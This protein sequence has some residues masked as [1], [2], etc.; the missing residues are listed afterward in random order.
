MTEFFNEIGSIPFLT[1][2]QEM[3]LAKTIQEGGVQGKKAFDKLVASNLRLVVSIAKEYVKHGVPLSDLIQEGSIGLMR[4]AEKFDWSMGYKFSTYA[5][6]W[7][8]QSI[9]RFLDDKGNVIR[10]PVHRQQQIN[11]YKKEIA[12][13]RQ[14]LGRKPTDSEV[15][16]RLGCSEEQLLTIKNSNLNTIYMDDTVGNGEHE[17]SVAEFLEDDKYDDAETNTCNKLI[18]YQLQKD[19]DSFL[20]KKERQ[21]IKMR[22]G[23]VDGS[24]QTLEEVGHYFGVT[25]E[26]IRQIECTAILKLRAVYK[27]RGIELSDCLV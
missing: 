18:N 2:E 13:L 22:F 26:R 6:W 20:T 5:S 21:V 12:F 23:F 27:K 24:A 9:T 3:E 16:A 8:K 10:I 14:E 15:A 19:M 17:R 25:R 7:I 11:N 1:Q 4:A